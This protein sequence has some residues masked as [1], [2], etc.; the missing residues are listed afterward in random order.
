MFWA[1]ILKFMDIV[2]IKNY[3]NMTGEFGLIIMF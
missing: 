2:H 1:A 3:I